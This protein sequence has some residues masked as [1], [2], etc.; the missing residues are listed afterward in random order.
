MK[1][2]DN[3][4]NAISLWPR[5]DSC[6]LI[7]PG[8]EGREVTLYGWV[9]RQRDMGNLI[10]VDLRDREGI[11]Q[12]VFSPARPEL[13]EA[14]KKLRP[15]YVIGIRGVSPTSARVVVVGEALGRLAPEPPD[16]LAPVPQAQRAPVARLGLGE[17]MDDGLSGSVERVRLVRRHE[18]GLVAGPLFPR[19]A[20]AHAS[21]GQGKRH[22][23][24]MVDVAPRLL[25]DSTDPQAA[26]A[27]ENDPAG[28]RDFHLRTTT[29]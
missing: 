23:H 6:G 11:I 12:I 20:E 15:E 1:M 14:A 4:S 29:A 9:Q 3:R 26:A 24:G 28:S 27:P 19:H 2:E 18:R 17:D 22:L 8:H 13:L 10:F 16:A 7:R 5:T 21:G 25:A